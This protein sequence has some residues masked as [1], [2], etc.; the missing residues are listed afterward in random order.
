[1][2]YIDLFSG[3]LGFSLG[4]HWAGMKF[5][6]HYISE[7][8]P[9]CC[10]L[11]KIRFPDAINL[12]DITKHEEWELADGEYIIT[13]GFPC[14][15]FSRTG[16]RKGKEDDRHLWPAMFGTI[17]QINPLW[18]IGE[19]VVGIDDMELDDVLS[20][21]ES[22][23]YEV[24]PPLEIP[25]LALGAYGERY[26]TW[27][28]AHARSKRGGFRPGSKREESQRSMVP[29]PEKIRAITWGGVERSIIHAIW[30]EKS[31]SAYLRSDYGLPDRVDR[32]RGI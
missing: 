17:Q 30:R 20:N 32:L 24:A 3:I 5:E 10:E 22:I 11:A 28:I 21:L 9:Y 15:P 23:G 18:V 31:P 6:N 2:N 7:I 12:G 14:Q 29:T 19:N 26:R 1:M 27:I 25:A 16:K 13:G 8:D 4:A